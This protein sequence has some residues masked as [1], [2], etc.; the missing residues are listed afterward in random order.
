MFLNR[1]PI[2]V[3]IMAAIGASGF[4]VAQAQTGLE[5]IVVTAQKREQSL[6]EV[7]ISIA[8]FSEEQ[9]ELRGIQEMEDLNTAVPNLSIGANSFAGEAQA[10]VFMRGL[11][12]VGIYIDGVWQAAGYGMVT[13]NVV[14]IERVEVLRG[15][16]GTLFGK[17]TSGGAIQFVTKK[18]GEELGGEVSIGVGTDSEANFS[19]S[20]D[21]PVSDSFRTRFSAAK[22]TR[23][24]FVTN[25]AGSGPDLGDIDNEV[26]RLDTIWEPLDSL[27]IR[28]SYTMNDF[29]QNGT[30]RVLSQI[31]RDED[32]NIVGTVF[33]GLVDY[34][35]D[36][37]QPWE[38]N[39]E[40]YVSGYSGGNLGQFD[41][42]AF[43]VED[44]WTQDSDEAALNITYDI[45]DALTIKSI[46]AW[47]EN[48]T[49]YITDYDATELGGF[50]D[51]SRRIDEQVTQEL[52]LIGSG[53]NLNWVLGY[54]WWDE[55][56]TGGSDSQFFGEM[57]GSVS[58]GNVVY[59][60]TQGAAYFADFTYQLSDQWAISLGARYSEE[61][62]QSTSATPI[63]TTA[64]GTLADAVTQS[65]SYFLD[66][67]VDSFNANMLEL[68]EDSTIVKANVSYQVTDDVMLYMAYSE[69]FNAG[70]LESI[71]YGGAT[72]GLAAANGIDLNDYFPIESSYEP[73]E[74][75]NIE[76]GI[77][78]DWLDGALRFNG[79]V[80][81]TDYTN[82]QTNSTVPIAEELLPLAPPDDNQTD[83]PGVNQVLNVAEGE[84]KGIEIESFWAFAEGWTLNANFGWIDAEYTSIGEAADPLQYPP[85]TPFRNTPE[86]SY[87]LGLL[88]R[89]DLS[90]GMLTTSVN[91]GWQDEVWLEES[92]DRSFRQDSYGLL[93]A[94]IVW[95]PAD[96][97]WRVSLYADNIT[98]EQYHISALASST[99]GGTLGAL[100][101]GSTFGAEFEYFFGD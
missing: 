81:L 91:Y 13:R 49:G 86:F 28:A 21:I 23:D 60:S 6:Q 97:D 10:Q 12:G 19:G 57:G 95:D 82:I 8:A 59:E 18:P 52:Q 65:T 79:T 80:F 47:R 44:S 87:S 33:G 40:N 42:T 67:D 85:G 31:I 62:A 14:D 7:P 54:Y 46:T 61:D 15:P 2:V 36:T 26:F 77:R 99:I 71:S 76:F 78:S 74:V 16:Q 89:L 39:E 11:P 66:Y 83:W 98:D 24:G 75:G 58:R 43:G 3:S 29:E 96:G 55:E 64:A 38:L 100:G 90:A 70:G 88:N 17:N 22:I 27:E 101:R 37:D 20:V 4:S 1:K 5:E 35:L 72:A 69:G 30:A 94:R 53:D 73:E 25:V 41:T 84:V 63:T 50:E 68:T 32:D 48:E 34:D 45:N 92:A 93:N 9:M 56:Q 51:Y